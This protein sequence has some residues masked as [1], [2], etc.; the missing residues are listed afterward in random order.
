MVR[1]RH[2]RLGAL[3]ILLAGSAGGLTPLRAGAQPPAGP[4]L[5]VLSTVKA[6]RSLSQDEAARGYPVRAR[7]T[8]T[9][10]DEREHGTLVIHESE[11]GQFVFPPTDVSTVRSW[12]DL[13]RGDPVATEG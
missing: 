12:P 4:R 9:H 2:S 3:V 5:P 7:A 1:V 13:Q 6:I 8:V 10:V 11:L